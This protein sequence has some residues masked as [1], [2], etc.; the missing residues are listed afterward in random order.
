MNK[1]IISAALVLATASAAFAE[2]N[3]VPGE[4]NPNPV[5]VQSSKIFEGRNAYEGRAQVGRVQAPVI[6]VEKNVFD[7]ASQTVDSGF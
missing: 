2:N 7:R 4:R 3:A 1:L 6:N 5:A